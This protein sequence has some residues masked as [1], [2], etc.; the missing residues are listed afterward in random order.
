MHI[1]SGVFLYFITPV[2]GI[3]PEALQQR[4]NMHFKGEICTNN[5]DKKVSP[6]TLPH[7]SKRPCYKTSCRDAS[8]KLIPFGFQLSRCDS[9]DELG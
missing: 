6:R 2:V 1:T 3:K 5:I 4:F 7:C 9:A 8:E